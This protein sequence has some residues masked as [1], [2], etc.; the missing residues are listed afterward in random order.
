MTSKRWHYKHCAFVFQVIADNSTRLLPKLICSSSIE[1]LLKLSSG[2]IKSALNYICIQK[3][4][5]ME[6]QTV[7]FVLF[8]RAGLC[9][10]YIFRVYKGP[11]FSLWRAVKINAL[12]KLKVLFNSS[13]EQLEWVLSDTQ[14]QDPPAWT[15]LNHNTLF[16][17][18]F[19]DTFHILV[20]SQLSQCCLTT[21]RAEQPA[22]WRGNLLFLVWGCTVT[23]QNTGKFPSKAGWS[24]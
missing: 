20:T 11:C 5:L 21:W 18:T 24:S 7:H 13:I 16:T 1:Q 9:N 6:M 8:C 19:Y 12:N 3:T 17:P 23:Y 2:P 14:D 10:F 22:A 15:R 4:G